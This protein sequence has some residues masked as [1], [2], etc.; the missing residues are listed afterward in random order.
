MRALIYL[1]LALCWFS[2]CLFHLAS[3]FPAVFLFELCI[4]ALLK[5]ISTM[6]P[7][8]FSVAWQLS[9]LQGLYIMLIRTSLVGGYVKDKS[10]LGV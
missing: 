2:T 4:A 7:L 9:Q 6:L 10:N 3:I 8:Q 5:A 1:A